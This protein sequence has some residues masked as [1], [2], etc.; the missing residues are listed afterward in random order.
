[1]DVCFN[2]WYYDKY[3]DSWN[4]YISCS[5][6]WV[7]IGLGIALIKPQ[8]C[9][10]NSVTIF[11]LIIVESRMLLTCSLVDSSWSCIF[12]GKEFGNIGFRLRS[13]I[14][15]SPTQSY[16]DAEHHNFFCMLIHVFSS[17]L[18]LSFFFTLKFNVYYAWLYDWRNLQMPSAG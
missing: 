15:L 16:R 5:R 18:F 7:K 11:H 1:M 17:Y 8:K 4:S 10:K 9:Y 13:V 3:P 12:W 14:Q 2:T 6:F